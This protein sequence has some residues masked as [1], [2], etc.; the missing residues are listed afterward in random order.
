MSLKLEVRPQT[1]AGLIFHL[2]QFQVPPYLELQVLEKQVS[3]GGG[4]MAKGQNWGW[5]GPPDAQ[6]PPRS[7]CGQTMVPASSPHR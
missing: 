1:A 4:S 6:P 3:R 2:G 7:C 5:Q